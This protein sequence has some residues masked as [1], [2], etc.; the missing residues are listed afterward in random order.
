M[1]NEL[2]DC[3]IIGAGVSG[4]AIARYLAKYQLKIAVLEKHNDVGEETTNAN[5]AI[6][7]SGYDPKPLSK[8]AYFNVLGNK[9]MPKLCEE[10]DVPFKKIG[11]LTVGFDD[12]DLK[13]LNDLLLR[14]QTNKV[15]ARII[16]QKELF[17]IEPNINKLA[18]CAL[19]CEDAGIISPFNLV[20]N[21]MENAMDNGVK[22]FLNW[23]VENIIKDNGLY[24]VTN[25]EGDTFKAKTLV[26]ASGVFADDINTLLEKS[27][28]KIIPRK[29]QYIVLDHFDSNFVKHVL[30][31]LPTKVG[32]GVLVAPTTSNNYIIGPSNEESLKDDT[33]TTVEVLNYV[34]ETATKLV[35]NIPFQESIRQFSGVRANVDRDDFIIQESTSNEGY[36]KVCG[37]MSPGLA[38]APAIGEYVANLVSTNLKAKENPQFNPS[39][40]KGLNLTTL[41]IDKYNEL[42]KSDPRYGNMICRCE[43]ISEGEIVDAISR[44]CGPTTVKG[45]KKRL[46]PGF[47][48]C[49]GTFCQDEVIK[50]LARELKIPLNE[51]NYSELHTEILKYK[52]KNHE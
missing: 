37:I 33:S 15:K 22:L 52:V 19:F 31:S 5:S 10:L 1:N 11:S 38:S 13:T 51:V 30:F 4:A 45:V 8:K 36:F 47:G 50:I 43:K 28:F 20:V 35:E 21:L 26:N 46:R 40:R 49:Q 32:K 2:F 41:G 9:M 48:K 12:E 7:H 14:A 34:K 27:D 39:I 29:G 17:K 3:L 6:V 44:N 42:I 23:E 24:I 25:K 18:T 16:E